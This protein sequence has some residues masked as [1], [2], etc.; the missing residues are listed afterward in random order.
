M[1]V[2]Q[3]KH[4]VLEPEKAKTLLKELNISSLQLPKIKK[5]D[6]ALPKDA[7]VGD[8]IKIERRLEDKK[9]LAYRVVVP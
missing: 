8:I 7:N 4:S 9:I 2:L 1:H 3:P 5:R 6:Q